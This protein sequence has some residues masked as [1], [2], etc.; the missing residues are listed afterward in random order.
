MM[1]KLGASMPKKRLT[2]SAELEATMTRILTS[3]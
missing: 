2:P 3:E 1:D